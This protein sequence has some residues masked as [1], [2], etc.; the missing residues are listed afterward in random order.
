M[1]PLC[2]FPD[3]SS[4]SNRI[5]DL[6]YPGREPIDSFDLPLK[7]AAVASSLDHPFPIG[8]Q[9]PSPSLPSHDISTLLHEPQRPQMSLSSHSS[10][11]SDLTPPTSL[12]GD[13]MFK[14]FPDT[15]MS[16]GVSSS[17][18]LEL[19][20][21]C[22]FAGETSSF[23]GDSPCASPS[24]VPSSTPLCSF[25]SPTRPHASVKKP[26]PQEIKKE[27]D[28]KPEPASIQVDAPSSIDKPIG[29]F[30]TTFCFL[31]KALDDLLYKYKHRR[32][33]GDAIPIM[34]KAILALSD[35]G[36]TDVSSIMKK[37]VKARDEMEVEA[38]EILAPGQVQPKRSSFTAPQREIMLSFINRGE[39]P[40]L[41]E[42]VH[43]VSRDAQLSDPK[44]FR[45]FLNNQ[46]ARRRGRK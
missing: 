46:R 30:L 19:F 37:F 6:P 33:L 5:S 26:I 12:F 18:P 35:E 25:S 28:C 8:T 22:H 39:M 2:Y 24:L 40:V 11:S 4:L 1:N 17:K 31:Y 9:Y 20:P 42:T 23:Q 10:H 16:A 15:L 38:P 21:S 32:K 36:V 27:I 44:Q 43:L 13:N 41:P 3:P 34:H 29:D 7:R 45:R 14:A